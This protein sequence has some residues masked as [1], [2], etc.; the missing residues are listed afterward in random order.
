MNGIGNHG[1]RVAKHTCHKLKHQQQH[2]HDAASERHFINSFVAIFHFFKN[3][4]ILV[5]KLNAHR[6]RHTDVV[7]R[8]E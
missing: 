1:G 7:E 2:V 8:V 5:D 3:D 4:S 6:F